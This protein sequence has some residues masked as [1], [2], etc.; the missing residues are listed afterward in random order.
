MI[1]IRNASISKDHFSPPNSS[2]NPPNNG[3]PIKYPVYAKDVTN[4]RDSEGSIPGTLPAL[5]ETIGLARLS[6]APDTAREI[7][8]IIVLYSSGKKDATTT[9]IRPIEDILPDN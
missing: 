7:V 8:A 9:N 3:G 2:A 5:E 6:P 1:E 4:D